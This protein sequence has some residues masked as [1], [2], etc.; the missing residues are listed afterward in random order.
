[1]LSI[2]SIEGAFRRDSEGTRLCSGTLFGGTSFDVDSV[3]AGGFALS[4]RGKEA[5]TVEEGKVGSDR[6]VA[7]LLCFRSVVLL[8]FVSAG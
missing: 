8:W 3:S 7:M 6:E 1:M 2:A 4:A 5:R